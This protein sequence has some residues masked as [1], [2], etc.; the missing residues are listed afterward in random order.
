MFTGAS[1]ESK[2]EE[3]WGKAADH[4]SQKSLRELTDTIT[5]IDDPKLQQSSFMQFMR[6]I[7]RGQVSF[8]D[9]QVS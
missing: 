9:N 4:T 1:E 5:K 8:A 3:A 7:N 6:K 2:M